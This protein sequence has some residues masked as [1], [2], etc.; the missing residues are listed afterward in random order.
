MTG[1]AGVPHITSQQERQKNQ[2]L[3]GTGAYI[4]NTGNQLEAVIQS[5]NEIEIKDGALMSQ[6]A[7]FSVPVGTVDSVTIQN[8][9]QGMKRKDLIV[10]RYSYTSG[11]NTESAEWVVIQ[12]T[13]DATS[14]VVPDPITGNIQEG[15]ATAD[16][17]VFVVSLDGINIESIETIPQMIPTIPSLYG[18][19][20]IGSSPS[21]GNHYIKFLDQGLMICFGTFKA[22]CELSQNGSWYTGASTQII[23]GNFAL[24]FSSLFTVNVSLSQGDWATIL[25]QAAGNQGITQVILGY[26]MPYSSREF[27]FDYVAF[28][29]F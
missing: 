10:A 7:L 12:G 28:G 17:P 25:N 11:S 6:G 15:A 4:L 20:E 16:T 23:D 5:A 26:S 29:L 9:T 27:R 21:N 18:N 2:G 13:P 3:W 14:P 8:G 24:P 22:V 1:R 19:I